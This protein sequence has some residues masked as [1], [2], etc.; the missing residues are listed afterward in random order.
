MSCWVNVTLNKTGLL[1]KIRAVPALQLVKENYVRDRISGEMYTYMRGRMYV[2]EF[3][4]NSFS[5]II[6]TN[7]AM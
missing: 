3:S 2:H 6:D 4:L 1:F 7:E 5:V